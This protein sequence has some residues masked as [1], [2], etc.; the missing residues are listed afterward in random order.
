MAENIKK[1]AI[2]IKRV[3]RKWFFLL[4]VFLQEAQ[5]TVVAST[6]KGSAYSQAEW[7]DRLN[8]AAVLRLMALHRMGDAANQVVAVRCS[9][10]PHHLITHRLGSFFDDARA[11]DLIRCDFEGIDVHSG[12]RPQNGT[13]GGLNAGALN[14]CVPIFESRPEINC[15]I[16]GHSKAIAVISILKGGVLPVTQPALYILPR[17]GYWPYV[18]D[19]D[20]GFR[21]AFA[22]A[23]KGNQVLLARNHGFYAI[24]KTPAEAFF[25]TFYLSQTCDIQAA[26]MACGDE[27]VRIPDVEAALI[28]EQMRTST[29]YHYDGSMEWPGWMRMVNRL[30]PDYCK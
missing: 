27:L 3:N 14:L 20:E 21:D 5:M 13:I 12:V 4:P 22:K 10:N 6:N 17:M 24:G 19:E 26:A 9:E 28:W 25:L 15:L 7:Q 11:S 8:V 18:F 2:N 16:H 29:E 30:A 23:F 1:Y